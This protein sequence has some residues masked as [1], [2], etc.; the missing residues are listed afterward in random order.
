MQVRPSPSLSVIPN[1][2]CISY[3][4]DIHLLMNINAKVTS[5]LYD[6]QAKSLHFKF[7]IRF[8]F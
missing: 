7:K 5:N 2:V 6:V 1:L 8:F 3:K 4:L